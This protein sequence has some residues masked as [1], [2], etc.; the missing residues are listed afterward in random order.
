MLK[1]QNTFG[2]MLCFA[3]VSHDGWSKHMWSDYEWQKAQTQVIKLCSVHPI[4]FLV[5]VQTNAGYICVTHA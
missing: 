3:Q 1:G 4:K 5:E 2:L